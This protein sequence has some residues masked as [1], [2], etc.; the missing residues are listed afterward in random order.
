MKA[1]LILLGLAVCTMVTGQKIFPGAVG[2]GTDSRG[3]YELYHNTN[4]ISDLPTILIVDTLSS[5]NFSTGTNR[6]TLRWCLNRSF[7]RIIV[8][9]RGGIINYSGVVGSVEI[10]DPYCNIY[11]QTAPG[12]GVTIRGANLSI[13]THDVL[14]QHLKVRFGDDPIGADPNAR[15]C[16]TTYDPSDNLVFD[17]CSFSW[18]MDEQVSFVNSTGHFTV[19]N[20]LMGEQLFRSY[21]YGGT[22]KIQEKHALFSIC[23][24]N[25]TQES[26]I[27]FYANA[28]G[29]VTGRTP[30]LY[31]NNTIIMNQVV[32][33]GKGALDMRNS[34]DDIAKVDLVNCYTSVID[35]PLLWTSIQDDIASVDNTQNPAS[36]LYVA[37][38]SCDYSRK[39]PSASQWSMVAK[40]E[41]VT[42]SATPTNDLSEY[43]IIPEGQVLDTV[44]KYAGAFYW[45][46]D[47]VD[48]RM[49]DSIRYEGNTMIDSPESIPAF[50][51]VMDNKYGGD[52]DGNL[53]D[54][55]DWS[56]DPQTLI[57]NGVSYTLNQN[58]SSVE[59]IVVYIN[60]LI[61]DDV[62]C[63]VL[64]PYITLD[65]I[66]FKTSEVGSD[67]VMTLDGTALET[68][69]MVAGTYH[70]LDMPGWD[71]TSGSKEL[72]I[73]ADPHGDDNSNGYTNVEEWAYFM[74]NPSEDCNFLSV[75]AS[76]TDETDGSNNGSIDITVSGGTPGYSYSWSDGSSSQDRSGLSANTY[77]VTVTDNEGCIADGSWT[78]NNNV[79]ANIPPSAAAGSDQTTTDSDDNGT[80]SV[81]LNGS[82]S[83]DSDGTI[84][85]YAWI[86]NSSTIA[87]GVNPTV[88]LSVGSHTITLR[89]TDNDGATDTDNLSVQVNAA[90]ITNNAPNVDDQDF[91]FLEEEEMTSFIG[92][93]LATANDAEQSLIYSILSGNEDDLFEIIAETG[94]LYFQDIPEDF[95]SVGAYELEIRVT[96][97]GTPSMN[98]VG[99][100]TVNMI[101][102]NK[103]YYIDPDNT[104]DALMDGSYEHPYDAWNA[105]SWE[106]NA[107]YL[108]KRGTSS[109]E[110]N[111]IDI[112]AEDVIL[113]AYGEGSN[114]VIVS[115]ASDYALQ[116]ENRSDITIRS[117]D[118]VAEDA[119]SC[120]YF[121]GELAENISI[122]NC[123]LE[124]PNY[125]IRIINGGS[126]TITQNTINNSEDGVY[127]IADY[128][129]VSYNNFI[130]NSNAINMKFSEGDSRIFNN[131][132]YDNEK[133]LVAEE[134]HSLIFN[135]IF[136]FEKNTEMAFDHKLEN[137]IADYNIYYPEQENIISLDGSTYTDF[138]SYKSATNMDKNSLTKDP[139]L[140]DQY[141]H[142]F[143]TE[144]GSPAIDAGIYMGT[145][146]DLYGTAVPIGDS[147]DIGS[148]EKDYV[149]GLGSRKVNDNSELLD[150]YPN[151]TAGQVYV[152]AN[153]ANSEVNRISVADQYGKLY[154]IKE[155]GPDQYNAKIGVDMSSLPSGIYYMRVELAN[156]QT[157]TKK[158]TKVE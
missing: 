81:T 143:E 25:P 29:F 8:F 129:D 46:R 60:S 48:Q 54:G 65:Y 62:I 57:V 92:T 118:I 36:R 27:T 16:V 64:N 71:L 149:L 77:S 120:I 87:T 61:P 45:N 109:I 155:I 84:V 141:N 100:I 12:K 119:T 157:I 28:L 127:L 107:R 63:Y 151:P 58:C 10:E 3:A 44:L 51:S 9:E 69:G 50:A 83:Y 38:N 139:M 47:V 116:S 80:Q 75:S 122:K 113:G 130:N 93:V 121:E 20:C 30:D 154:T 95:Y 111:S 90:V 35:H 2:Y 52:T 43:H 86:E 153:E 78:V 49:V 66:A 74:A 59:E 124:N 158:V 156:N 89:V 11:G 101:P 26:Y 17:H 125:C 18:G 73:P 117:L 106:N 68:F 94:D 133:G 99:T 55:K 147:P 98:D 5:G 110:A 41:R 7:P 97:D 135:N 1:K 115:E 85:S 132:F 6:G 32:H 128:V 53:P 108:Q 14:V 138:E 136:Y 76:V 82:G 15:D 34:A 114:P 102:S 137:C 70:G 4:N 22:D 142:D 131:V 105:V 79:T 24:K 140:K 150:V 21:H 126:F 31:I 112:I 146:Q 37:G 13:Q 152:E 42:Q 88:T 134:G 144:D 91:D 145:L 33:G 148:Y 39:N 96:D 19:S 67:Q 72:D 40:S 23:G 103:V 56:S 104:G 123:T